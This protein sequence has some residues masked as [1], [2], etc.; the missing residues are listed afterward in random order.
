MIQVG[1]RDIAGALG[2]M[3]A[4]WKATGR[5]RGARA[6]RRPAAEPLRSVATSDR[7]R[8]MRLARAGRHVIARPRLAA[9]PGSPTPHCAPTSPMP[10]H[11]QPPCATAHHT[12]VQGGGT[13][14]TKP[15]MQTQNSFYCTG[16]EPYMYIVK[17][18]PVWDGLSLF[19][20][21]HRSI[22][23]LEVQ[24]G[25]WCLSIVIVRSP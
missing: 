17:W 14:Q 2:P 13:G 6:P 4:Y 15:R 11:V 5:A 16:P 22:G 23:T 24:I 25:F 8:R 18:R 7:N 9:G 12:H 19:V 20:Y 1:D 3:R 10:P 21:M